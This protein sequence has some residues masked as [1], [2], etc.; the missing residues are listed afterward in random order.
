RRLEAGELSLGVGGEGD[1]DGGAVGRQCELRGDRLSAE[2]H[3]SI[4]VAAGQ[5]EVEP[6]GTIAEVG[7]FALPASAA[8]RR[9]GDRIAIRVQR[10]GR[11]EAVRRNRSACNGL[12]DLSIDRAGDPDMPRFTLRVERRVQR[13]GYRL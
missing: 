5:F 7:R 1:V 13:D 9:Y 2:G 8:V 12:I 11:P 4:D 10:G 6:D 3:R